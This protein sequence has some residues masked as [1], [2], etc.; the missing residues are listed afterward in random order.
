MRNY[1]L[2]SFGFALNVSWLCLQRTG[3]LIAET[4]IIDCMRVVEK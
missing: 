1:L 2:Q 3:L 4:A